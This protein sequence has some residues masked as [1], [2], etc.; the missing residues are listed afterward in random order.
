MTL[1][2]RKRVANSEANK[3]AGAEDFPRAFLSRGKQTRRGISA[4]GAAFHGLTMYDINGLGNVEQKTTEQ[5][6]DK[7]LTMKRN[8]SAG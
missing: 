4:R 3:Y 8:E 7:I 5:G 2:M 1:F 6:T